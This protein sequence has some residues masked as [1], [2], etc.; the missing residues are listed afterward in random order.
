MRRDEAIFVLAQRE[1][2]ALTRDAR[3]A[4]LLDWW[5]IDEL[6]PEFEGL[7]AAIRSRLAGLDEPDD[8]M[9]P[10]F[11]SLLLVA[12]RRAFVGVLNSYLQQRMASIGVVVVV[13]G[14]VEQLVACPCCRYRTLRRGGEF[15]ICKVCFWE[16]DGTGSLDVRS[17]P[18][19]MTLREAR[20][21]FHRIGAASVSAQ[22]HVLP[23]GA[24]RY[25][26]EEQHPLN[27]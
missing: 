24:M 23:D 8:C 18:N 12:C 19:R 1:V 6:D 4:M 25:V 10:V 7:P 27:T 2:A 21:N 26:R 9:D 15:E 14:A 17:A 3:Q 11:D 5:T 13:E 20:S 22:A 16:D